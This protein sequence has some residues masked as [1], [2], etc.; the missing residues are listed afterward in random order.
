M[1][2]HRLLSKLTII[3]FILILVSSCATFHKING[4]S[5]YKQIVLQEGDR[6]EVTTTDNT[7]MNFTIKRID[8]ENIYGE[9][10]DQVINKA[11]IKSLEVSRFNSIK[12]FAIY[13][14][15][16]MFSIMFSG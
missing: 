3:V 7:K 1:V 9:H 2:I 12:Y 13:I 10:K 14:G 5:D 8:S 15:L 6:I 11:K 4:V 16:I